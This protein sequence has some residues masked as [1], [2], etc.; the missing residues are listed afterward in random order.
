MLLLSHISHVQGMNRA[1]ALTEH[2]EQQQDCF[3]CRHTAD[4]LFITWH[5]N[6]SYCLSCVE[7]NTVT[8]RED[9]ALYTMASVMN[10]N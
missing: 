1:P 7:V 9:T 4:T 8:K 5:S 2:T 6:Y 10:V 3:H